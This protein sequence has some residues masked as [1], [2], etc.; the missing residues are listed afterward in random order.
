VEKT[1]DENK[2]DDIAILNDA[3]S[4]LFSSYNR[5]HGSIEKFKRWNNLVI[6][7]TTDVWSENREAIKKFNKIK[8]G[9]DGG[10]TITRW[11]LKKKKRDVYFE[12]EI[13]LFLVKD[14]NAKTEK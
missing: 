5:D 13:P 12:W 11:F 9:E 3:I 10:A 1:K 7:A 8:I 2:R 6:V 4:D 14:L